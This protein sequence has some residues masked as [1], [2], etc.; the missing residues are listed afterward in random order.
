MRQIVA[1]LGLVALAAG[2]GSAETIETI[3]TRPGVGVRFIVTAPK[4][5]PV[6]AAILFAGGDGNFRLPRDRPRLANNFL[7]RAR[8]L[9]ARAGVLTL[10]L[11]AP[12]D[13]RAEGL[14]GFRDSAAHRTDLAAVIRRALTGAPRVAARLFDCG[15]PSQSRRR[16]ARAPHG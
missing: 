9:F 11:D 4:G 5:P 6:A 14:A 2:N 3:A 10:T 7:V 13:R 15:R 8:A 12:S 1:A 16:G